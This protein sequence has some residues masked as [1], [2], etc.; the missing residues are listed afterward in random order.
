[1]PDWSGKTVV[2]IGGGPSLT[3]R[4]CDRIEASGFPSV[5]VNSSWKVA[6]FATVIYAADDVWWK[7]YGHDIDIPAERWT[8][9]ENTATAFGINR[10]GNFVGSLNS[11]L[12]AIQFALHSGAE[13]VLLVGY[14][15][16]VKHGTHHHGDHPSTGNPDAETC[17][18]WQKQ[19]ARL[20]EDIAAGKVINCSLQTELRAF[21]R[22]N[23]EDYLC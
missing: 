5:A 17:E 16:S 13:R 14:D 9:S 11:G 22:G 19:F 18:K 1:M 2:C 3:Q 21:P 8:C 20:A 6:R 12:R 15:C 23:L 10:H 7:H 4:Q